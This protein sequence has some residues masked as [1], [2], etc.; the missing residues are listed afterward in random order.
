MYR[1]GFYLK[2]VSFEVGTVKISAP[3]AGTI[4]AVPAIS[5]S[6][7]WH[8]TFIMLLLDFTACSLLLFDLF[9]K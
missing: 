4:P 6:I 8:I 5:D 2:I 7:D 3:S 1:V 9:E